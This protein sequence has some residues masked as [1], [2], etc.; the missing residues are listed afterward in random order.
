MD[1]IERQASE[2]W[3]MGHAVAAM[4]L[5]TVDI[6]PHEA[7]A[8]AVPQTVSVVVGVVPLVLGITTT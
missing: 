6:P 2:A 1:E 5:M 8:Q 3:G 7:V 4:D